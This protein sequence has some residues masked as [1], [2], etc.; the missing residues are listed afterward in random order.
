MVLLGYFK[1]GE[2]GCVY[3]STKKYLMLFRC[4]CEIVK[5]LHQDNFCMDVASYC[6][7]SR[8]LPLT[9]YKEA[10]S[11]SHQF[12]STHTYICSLY[13]SGIAYSSTV[14]KRCFDFNR[15]I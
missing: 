6:G 7:L 10:W 4:L 2:V 9:H 12:F 15:S 14:F 11:I 5:T 13:M 8:G 3:R 1:I